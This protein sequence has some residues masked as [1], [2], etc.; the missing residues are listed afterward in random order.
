[1]SNKL[2]PTDLGEFASDLDGGIFGEKVAQ[3]ISDIASSVVSEEVNLNRQ[4]GKLTLSFT[5]KRFGTSGAQVMVS[6]KLDANIPTPHGHVNEVETKETPMFVNQ[7]GNCSF[8][9]ED[10]GEL[11]TKRGEIAE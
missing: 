1:M 3:F 2:K 11:F 4:S 6:H 5:F 7:G 10:Q 8:F 9:M